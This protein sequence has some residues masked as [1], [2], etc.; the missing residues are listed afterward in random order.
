MVVPSCPDVVGIPP[1]LRRPASPDP[2]SVARDTPRKT[3]CFQW[4]DSALLPF[5][6]NAQGQFPRVICRSIEVLKQIV[7]N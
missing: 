1:R 4:L 7:S 3:F 5:H 6:G 2:A